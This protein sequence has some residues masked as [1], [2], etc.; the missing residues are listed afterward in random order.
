MHLQLKKVDIL[1]LKVDIFT[2]PGK[3][4]S[5][6]PII[7]T[8]E[9]RNYSSSQLR[10]KTMETYFKTYCF[11]SNILKHVTKECTFCYAFLLRF[12]QVTL[13]TL[14]ILFLDFFN[15]N[16]VFFRPLVPAECK[17]FYQFKIINYYSLILSQL[18]KNIKFLQMCICDKQC[19]SFDRIHK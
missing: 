17:R 1:T 10:E 11:K 19:Y 2:T 3:T 9:E 6:V 15:S 4:L 16:W 12:L 14:H 8:Q 7:S 13:I 18:N 5:Q